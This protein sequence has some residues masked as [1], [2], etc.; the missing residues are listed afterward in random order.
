MIL[1]IPSFISTLIILINN[2]YTL[3]V[4]KKQSKLRTSRAY[5]SV[6][7]LTNK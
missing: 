2:S 3:L 7:I 4:H 6:F 5:L 1:Y